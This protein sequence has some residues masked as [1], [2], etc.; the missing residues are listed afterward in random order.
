LDVRIYAIA[1]LAILNVNLDNIAK[2]Y[3]SDIDKDEDL[4]VSRERANPL[5]NPRAAARRKGGFANNWR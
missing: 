4:Q 3:F 1:A 2:R 5:A